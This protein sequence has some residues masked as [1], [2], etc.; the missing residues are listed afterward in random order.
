MKKPV[1]N[2]KVCY[3]QEF[4]SSEHSGGDGPYQG[5]TETIYSSDVISFT[6]TED[7]KSLHFHWVPDGYYDFDPDGEMPKEAECVF[8]RYSDGGTFGRSSGY[9]F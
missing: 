9:F 3:E 2:L 7:P 6:N 1:K 8:V 4:V 5:F